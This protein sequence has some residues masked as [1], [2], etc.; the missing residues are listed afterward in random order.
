[1]QHLRTNCSCGARQLFNRRNDGKK[2]SSAFYNF[3]MLVSVCFGW[4]I[5][6]AF[7][8]SFELSVIP[9]SV[10][11]ATSYTVCNM[12]IINAL[13]YGPT[14]LTSL[15]VGL[16]L[17]LTTIWGFIFWNAKITVPVII[18]L[19]FVVIAIYLCLYTDKKEEKTVS[20]KWLFFVLLGFFGNAGCSIIQR[21]Q[22]VKF[23]GQHGSMLMLFAAF[24][25]AAACF[26]IYLKSDKRDT[27]A[28]LRR[29]WW[30]PV[31]AG[32]CNVVLN[33]FVMLMALSTLSPSLIYPVIG[34][35]GL[36]VVTVF[37]LV[38]FKEKM[39]WRQWLGV[40]IGVAAIG[41]LSV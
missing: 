40:G 20:W 15:F 23:H 27:A 19:V 3:F 17:I 32:A 38:A 30:V 6:Y 7:H 9:Y 21:T 16:S 11:F 39:Y 1:M 35:G 5:M 34:V 37:S 31:S 26:V 12:G 36:V 28:M 13:K 4:G 18:G 8:F 2:D 10:L 33:L 41:I 22:Q 29:S 25:S 14:A 24:L